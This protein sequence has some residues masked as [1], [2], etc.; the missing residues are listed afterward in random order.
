M[1]A[2]FITLRIAHLLLFYSAEQAAGISAVYQVA[3]VLAFCQHFHQSILPVFRIQIESQPYQSGGGDNAETDADPLVYTCHIHNHKDYE[4][5]QQTARKD[6]EILTFQ[7]LKF[8]A[9]A[10]AF[11]N[12]MLH[13]LLFFGN[14]LQKEGT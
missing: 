11:I 3:R 6:E 9:L 8:H 10:N 13:F 7:A 4:Y 5:S 14:G 12:I 2:A 1:V